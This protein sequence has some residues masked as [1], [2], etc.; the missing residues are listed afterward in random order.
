MRSSVRSIGVALRTSFQADRWRATGVFVVQPVVGVLGALVGVWLKL[1]TDGVVEGDLGKAVIGAVLCGM[2]SI[3]GLAVGLTIFTMSM[4]LREATDLEVD[5]ALI[6][7][8]GRVP[9]VEHYERPEYLDRLELLRTGRSGLSQVVGPLSHGLSVLFEVVTT[10]GVLFTV[11]P[12]LAVLPAFGVPSLIVTTRTQRQLEEMQERTAEPRREALHLFDLATTAGPGKEV[13]VFGLD[14]ELIDRHDRLWGE[15]DRMQRT[16]YYRV[17]LLRALGWTIFA[18]GF[19][20]AVALVTREAVAGRATPG[21]V[22]LALWVGIHI[23]STVGGIGGLLSWLVNSLKTVGRYLWLVDYARDAELAAEAAGERLPT[24]ARLVEGLRL[25]Q[26]SFAYPGTDHVVLEDVN[27][28]IPAQS[29]VAIVGD[30]GA[31]K[32]TLVK[33]LARMYEP[34]DGVITIDGIDLARLD[35]VEWR[36]RLSAGFQDFA[37]YEVEAMTNVGLGD[38]ARIDDRAAATAALERA[39][40]P[41]LIAEMADGLDTMLGASAGG[42]ELSGG[43]WQKLALGRAMMRE[44]PLVLL[45]DEP[46]AAIDAET[47]YALFEGYAAASRQIAAETGGITIL[48][49]HR[50]S[51]VRMADLIVVVVGGRIVESGGHAELMANRGLYA[52]LYEL[53][54]GGYR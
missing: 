20:L 53:Q 10:A 26:V 33:L 40:A 54:A 17:A 6:D 5:R 21:D 19:A 32:T 30:N 36:E 39:G 44:R 16:A 9:G 7:L 24:P 13:R 29:T 4:R 51:T 1:I 3:V 50:F 12:I 15:I 11:H 52:E 42:G 31:G 49:S 27:L 22:V 35:P 34:T 45:L 25:D 23:N 41:G 28:F 43:Q 14:H 18:A 2:G 46:T 37:R 47:E 8:A 48:V 38:L